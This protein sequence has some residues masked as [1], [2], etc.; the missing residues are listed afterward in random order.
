MMMEAGPL[1]H[2]DHSRMATLFTIA[3]MGFS[4]G[5]MQLPLK[6][7]IF[8][9]Y[10]E[11]NSFSMDHLWLQICRDTQNSI[12]F[13]AISKIRLLG[14]SC[15]SYYMLTSVVCSLTILLKRCSRGSHRKLTLAVQSISSETNQASRWHILWI[16]HK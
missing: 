9:R 14:K 7:V 12:G 4:G 8:S 3:Y 5:I 13:V 16:I 11:W 1:A 15:S 2:S 6:S 10:L